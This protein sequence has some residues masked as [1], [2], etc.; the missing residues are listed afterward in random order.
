VKYHYRLGWNLLLVSLVLLALQ[1]FGLREASAQATE[2]FVSPSGSGTDCSQSNPCEPGQAMTN[3]VTGDTIYF[4]AGTYSSTNDPYL[5]INKAVS[6]RGGWDGSATGDVVVNADSYGTY[7]DGGDTRALF[8]V[9]DT[10]GLGELTTISGFTF[11]NGHANN[12]GGAIDIQNGRGEV[13]DN[14]FFD[15]YSVS[16][17][18]AIAN[19][20][21]YDVQILGNRFMDNEAQYGGGSIIASSSGSATTLIEDNLFSG[22]NAMYGS[23]IHN[24]SCSLIINRNTFMD[25]LGDTLIRLSSEG[26]SATVSNNFI[27]RPAG[28]AISSSGTHASPFQIIN[29]TFV[30]GTFGIFSNSDLVNIMNNIFSGVN[31]S[32]SGLSGSLTG[33]NNLFYGNSNDPNQL[34]DPVSADPDFINPTGDDYHISKDSPAID[35]GATVALSDDFD[36]DERPSG[37]GY[38]I[39]ADEVRSEYLVYLPLVLK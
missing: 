18:G 39:G 13:I 21:A 12:Y 8:V 23:A 17:G 2:L 9:N 34:T 36:G 15:N 37:D 22:G 38:D 20:S 28:T 16:Y 14:T 7:I 4:M 5:V 6:L 26:P 33:S 27:I 29:N 25:T 35:A 32:I 31:T 11:Q 10:T 19:R 1:P 24:D 3:A 30:G